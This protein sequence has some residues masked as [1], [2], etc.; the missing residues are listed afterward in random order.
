MNQPAYR[1]P[2]PG[3]VF[4]L[5]GMG[6]LVEV[7]ESMAYREGYTIQGPNMS[8]LGQ[9]P[10]SP[11]PHHES[12]EHSPKY[13]HHTKIPA[14]YV[15]SLILDG[16]PNSVA[17]DSVPIRPEDFV[18]KR[19][20]FAC[21]GDTP[22]FLTRGVAAGSTQGRAVTIQ[23]QDEFTKFLGSRPSLISALFGD[24]NGFLDFPRGILL[25][26]KQTLSVN[27]TRLFWP[28]PANGTTPAKTQFDF[29]FHGVGL[30]PPGVN[31]SGSAG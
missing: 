27:L 6:Q 23:W 9:H 24:S 15:I 2:S 19:I 4:A 13:R 1:F 10:Q 31:Q 12:I 25:Q 14:W 3:N 26:G 8:G 16:T 30:L 29:V 20:T 5:N 21:S 28:D 11:D 18:C 22:L 17:G 7:P